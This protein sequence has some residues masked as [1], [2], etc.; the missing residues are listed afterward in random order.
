MI[1]CRNGIDEIGDAMFAVGRC[2]L[3]R[4]GLGWERDNGQVRQGSWDEGE[5]SYGN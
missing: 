1:A 3:L 4:G 5:V 2:N